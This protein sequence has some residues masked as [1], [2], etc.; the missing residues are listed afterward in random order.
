[1][2]FTPLTTAVLGFF[3]SSVSAMPTA[4]L[5]RDVST[6]QYE[7]STLKTH[8]M[9]KNSG[10]ADGSWPPGSEFNSTIELVI[11]YPSAV[12]ESTIPET[13]TCTANW[14]YG[15]HPADWVLCDDANLAWKFTEFSTEASFTIEVGRK[16][17]EGNVYTGSVRITSNRQDNDSWFTC[18]GGAPTTGINCNLDGIMSQQKSPIPVGIAP[19][20]SASF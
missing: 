14:V 12:A 1:M 19:D 17:S 10:I 9:G 6:T 7:I 18:I 2:Q 20:P 8:F 4:L 11:N 15:T 3:L 5:N 16:F 13:A